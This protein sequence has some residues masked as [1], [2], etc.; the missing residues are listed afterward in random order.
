[1]VVFDTRGD[2]RHGAARPAMVRHPEDGEGVT[3]VTTLVHPQPGGAV[4]RKEESWSVR[5][6][7]DDRLRA[8]PM[9]SGPS[10]AAGGGRLDMAPA[11]YGQTPRG[12]SAM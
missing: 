6:V 10:I 12:E 9:R 7:A 5:P 11:A 8:D 2:A 1:M 3:L 4:R